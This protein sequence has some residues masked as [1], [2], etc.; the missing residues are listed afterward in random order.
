MTPTYC[1]L[2]ADQRREAITNDE[3]LSMLVLHH[4]A[5]DLTGL[6]GSEIA[7]RF[8]SE[9]GAGR[10]HRPG[11]PALGFVYVHAPSETYIRADQPRTQ[12]SH[13]ILHETR[14]VWQFRTEA[15]LDTQEAEET[16]ADGFAR[17]YLPKVQS[18]LGE[19]VRRALRRL[20][21]TSHPLDPSA[22]VIRS[23][24]NGVAETVVD[25]AGM[26]RAEGRLFVSDPA[27]ARAQAG[28]SAPDVEQIV[29]RVMRRMLSRPDVTVHGGCNC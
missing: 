7:L 15:P 29:Q 3:F 24:L 17:Y 26:E 10:C 5:A 11:G 28:G 18:L 23:I 20:A 14:H 21:R 4:I 19:A 12:R 9:S 6:R 1:E 25:E 13:V 16:D 2:S 27:A 22:A 8:V